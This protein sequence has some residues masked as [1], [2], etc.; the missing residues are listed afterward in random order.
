MNLFLKKWNL[1]STRSWVVQRAMLHNSQAPSYSLFLRISRAGQPNISMNRILDQWVQEGGPVRHFE[2]RFFIKQ[3]RSHRRFNHALQVL[4]WMGDERKHHLT[5]GDIAVRLDL[6][7]KV[8]GLGPA[9]KYFNSISDSVK[10]FKVYSALLNC[11]TQ[12]NSVEKAE[13]TM[14]KLKEYACKHTI[15]LVLS[16]NAL[17]KLYVRV[18]EYDKFDSLMR[19]MLSKDMYDSVSLNTRL[20][21]YA[22][23]KDIDGL[24]SLLLRMEADPKATIDWITYSIA[25]KAYIQAGQHEKAYAMLRKSEDLIEPKRRRAA[26]GSLLTMY[27]SMG[28]KED[29]YRIW[30]MCKR[31]NRP[32]NANYI[33]MLT[34]LARLNDVD[35]AERIFEEWESGNTC[36]DIRIPNVMMSA[37]CKNGLVEKAEAFIDRLSKSRNELGGS[38]WDRLAHGYYRNNDMDNAIQTMKKAILGGQPGSTW[39][40]YRFTLATC[41]D[42]LK[43]KGDLEGASEILRLCLERGYFSTVIHDR[44]SSY[45]HGKTPETKAINLMEEYYHPKNDE[46]FPDGEKQH[47]IQLHE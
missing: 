24:E 1:F 15:D 35:G 29:V 27:G 20:N 23:V 47:E 17:L 25:A 33:S 3:L 18:S 7:A 12:H 40:P 46:L 39:K 26:Y 28:K 4:E 5:S 10:D 22:V 6:I 16:Y 44:L 9:E 31:L 32:C 30:D 36:F 14:Q 37:Y 19:E 45:V 21:A 43:D 34:A 13:A 42:Y 8:H 41:I 11:Y 38:I 2:L